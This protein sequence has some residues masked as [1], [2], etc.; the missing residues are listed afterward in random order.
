MVSSGSMQLI[1]L[2]D[3]YLKIGQLTLADFLCYS[4]AM[5]KLIIF[6]L[7]IFLP[8]SL[9]AMANSEETK[10]VIEFETTDIFGNSVNS[11]DIFK[12]SKITM[13]NFWATY[14]RPCIGE[15]P[16]LA[17]IPET[18]SSDELQI[19]GIITDVTS[20]EAYNS[21]ITL[22]KEKGAGTYMHLLPSQS[23]ISILNN[24]SAVPTTLFVN[25]KGEVIKSVVGSNTLKKWMEIIDSL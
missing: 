4:K 7:L 1:N 9:F 23:M 14:C 11:N 18:Y 5:K 2:L 13:I 21:A 15:L 25:N 12:S 24:I 20:Q 19:I 10:A 8:L 17:Q 6:A 3:N 16:F 22:I